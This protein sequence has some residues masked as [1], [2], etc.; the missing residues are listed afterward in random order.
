MYSDY[1]SGILIPVLL[2]CR[3]L[4]INNDSYQFND[5]VCL[6]R[7]AVACSCRTD[8][9]ISGLNGPHLAIVIVLRSTLQNI[10]QFRILIMQMIAYAASRVEGDFGEK[11]SGLSVILEKRRPLPFSSSGPLMK[12]VS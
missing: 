10:K 3:S 9:N 11:A 4:R 2:P 12:W 8:C 5:L 1:G 6:V 7:Y